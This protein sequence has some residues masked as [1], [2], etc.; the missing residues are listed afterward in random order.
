MTDQKIGYD[1]PQNDAEFTPSWTY[2]SKRLK[3]HHRGM[4]PHT[5][6][7][8]ATKTKINGKGW[9]D[10]RNDDIKP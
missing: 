7:F 8:P 6:P 2:A 9:K 1:N 5:Q 3:C 10:Y 4:E